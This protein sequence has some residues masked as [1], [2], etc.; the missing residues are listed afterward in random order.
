MSYRRVDLVVAEAEVAGGGAAVVDSMAAVAAV[1]DS[2]VE[3]AENSVAEAAGPE[4]MRVVLVAG[5]EDR[6]V[7]RNRRAGA[8]DWPNTGLA[9]VRCTGHSGRAFLQTGLECDRAKAGPANVGAEA[10]ARQRDQVKAGRES[11]MFGTRLVAGRSSVAVDSIRSTDLAAVRFLAAGTAG[12]MWVRKAVRSSTAASRVRSLALAAE[13]L[14]AA[15]AAPRSL[16]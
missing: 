10:A 3:V 14:P 16:V 11:G 1:V 8:A 7:D 5:A 4:C 13:R 9:I 15:K 12:P 6:C 2:M